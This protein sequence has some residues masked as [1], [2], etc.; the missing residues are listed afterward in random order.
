[1]ASQQALEVVDFATYVLRFAR[2]HGDGFRGAFQQ[3]LD[4]WRRK[5][6]QLISA[7]SILN[8]YGLLCNL[9]YS[10]RGGDAFPTAA[11][12]HRVLH[13]AS[14]A[15]P[16]EHLERLAKLVEG[17]H[18]D[19]NAQ[20]AAANLRA[21]AAYVRGET[22]ALPDDGPLQPGSA[23]DVLL[24]DHVRKA[25]I[26]SLA[27]TLSCPLQRLAQVAQGL[28]PGLGKFVAAHVPQLLS[29]AL[30]DVENAMTRVLQDGAGRSGSAEHRRRRPRALVALCGDRVVGFASLSSRE[31]RVVVRPYGCRCHHDREGHDAAAGA[32]QKGSTSAPGP[33]APGPRDPLQTL[34]VGAVRAARAGSDVVDVHVVGGSFSRDAYHA[35]EAVFEY[36]QTTSD[37]L[38]GELDGD[39]GDAPLSLHHGNLALLLGEFA[40]IP[41][42]KITENLEDLYRGDDA[43][44]ENEV[45]VS[46]LVHLLNRQ[47]V[48]GTIYSGRT[49]TMPEEPRPRPTN[50]EAGFAGPGANAGAGFLA[51]VRTM[52]GCPERDR[53]AAARDEGA[54]PFDKVRTTGVALPTS[55]AEVQDEM[56]AFLEKRRARQKG[57]PSDGKGN[58]LE[59]EG[60]RPVD[61]PDARPADDPMA[62]PAT[63]PA[64]PPRRKM[65]PAGAVATPL[66]GLGSDGL[67][68][69]RRRRAAAQ[70]GNAEASFDDTL[71]MI[72]YDPSVSVDARAHEACIVG[73]TDR[74]ALCTLFCKVYP[75]RSRNAAQW[76]V[77]HAA[78]LT[79][80]VC[81]GAAW[82]Q[83]DGEKA[84]VAELK[85]YLKRKLRDLA[86]A[87]RD[88]NPER[89]VVGATQDDLE[90]YDLAAR[91][92]LAQY[93]MARWIARHPYTKFA[94]RGRAAL[95]AIRAAVLERQR[96]DGA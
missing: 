58:V 47:F 72:S 42:Q 61:D 66:A 71:A 48:V 31:G 8:W 65:L 81:A 15:K 55:E 28:H 87:A 92:P 38:R 2:V 25:L 84:V 16:D 39:N 86:V 21:T 57:S 93:Q 60:T 89:P 29:T 24:R 22:D 17:D 32:H 35:L 4:A 59:S 20:E 83:D 40:R 75:W 94:G 54:T 64:A 78:A 63:P 43:G 69:L 70:K 76:W 34:V 62:G 23:A 95:P 50:A 88:H 19:D 52:L 77:C 6:D 5:R 85:G 49:Q 53:P 44:A 10:K 82:P 12:A 27:H 7:K 80:R 46:A 91:E 37:R 30:T 14:P 79:V 36:N 9:V 51:A 45:Q 96:N 90:E 11:D 33:R 56:Q 13:E 18:S 26:D 1:M 74:A 68:A 67:A 3:R 41:L 73:E